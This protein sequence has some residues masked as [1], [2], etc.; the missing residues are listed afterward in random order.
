MVLVLLQ[1]S[2]L[3]RDM[4]SVKCLWCCSSPFAREIHGFSVVLQRS[5]LERYM[6]SMRCL[7]CCIVLLSRETC[8]QC[9]AYGAAAFFS[10]EIHGFSEVLVVLQLPVY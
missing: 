1:R 6:V 2:S 5:S 7:W 4:V 3:E 9:G 10:R 8:F